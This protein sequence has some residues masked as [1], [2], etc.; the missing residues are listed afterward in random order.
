V[1]Y[2]YR[3]A[4]K[5]TECTLSSDKA[6]RSVGQKLLPMLSVFADWASHHSVYLQSKDTGDLNTNTSSNNN[7]VLSSPEE[8]LA[9]PAVFRE[10][11]EQ[12]PAT[13]TANA[14]NSSTDAK[15]AN[16]VILTEADWKNKYLVDREE[17]RNEVRIRST[18]K[19]A[20]SMM[21]EDLEKYAQG[22][23]D[24]VLSTVKPGMV[25]R[26]HAELRGY[27]PVIHSSEVTTS[28]ISYMSA[29]IIC[30]MYLETI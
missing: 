6:K 9:I 7:V 10:T 19:A 15:Y 14:T 12:L 8:D 24:D 18:M 2:I 1:V 16:D 30:T 17:V 13:I 5:W 20:L 22:R 27:L 26:E 11:L 4:S 23:T 29:L 25:L 3:V 21:K 28:Q